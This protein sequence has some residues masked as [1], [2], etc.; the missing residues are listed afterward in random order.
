MGDTESLT[1]QISQRLSASI[2]A[3]KGA[4]S[5][6]AL[7]DRI[8]ATGCAVREQEL[9]R[10]Q[11]A[12]GKSNALPALDRLPKLAEA[13][14]ISLAWLLTGRAGSAEVAPPRSREPERRTFAPKPG[15]ADAAPRRASLESDR[16][17]RRR[18]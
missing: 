5:M 14:G 17:A 10:W 13:L 2:I 3:A 1:E 6:A 12:P 7:R 8:A 4:G 9:F 15:A 16:K 11:A 18:A